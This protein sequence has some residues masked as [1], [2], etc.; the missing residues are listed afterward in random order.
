MIIHVNRGMNMNTVKSFKTV[1]LLSIALF[2]IVS[3]TLGREIKYD[4]E[5]SERLLQ[6][7]W[8]GNLAEVKTALSDGTDVNIKDEK[9][10]TALLLA[11]CNGH[12]DVV[13]F[14][15]DK[16]ANVNIKNDGYGFT[17]IMLASRGG[18]RDV[19]KLLLDTGAEVNM[20]NNDGFTALMRAS[21]E[22]HLD[23]STGM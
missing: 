15:L 21:R 2:A 20:K 1:V 8:S 12:I 7:A 10:N 19:V 17:A 14:L 16:G 6:A 3:S 13:K 4:A 5:A 11:S 23:V 22:G 18:H 9:G